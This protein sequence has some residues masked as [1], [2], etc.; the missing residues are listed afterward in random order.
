[1]T[2]LNRQILVDTGVTKDKSIHNDLNIN[3]PQYVT[4]TPRHPHENGDP[5]LNKHHS[6]LKTLM[7][8]GF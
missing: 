6:Q 1:M 2:W 5:A 4:S 7:N 3:I 8:I